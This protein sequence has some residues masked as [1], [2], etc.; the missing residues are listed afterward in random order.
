MVQQSSESRIASLL[1]ITGVA[2]SSLLLASAAMAWTGAVP[3]AVDNNPDPNIFETTLNV[4]RILSWD[5]TKEGETPAMVAEYGIAFNDQVPGPTI[6][7]K[8]GDRVIVHVNNN[9]PSNLVNGEEQFIENFITVHWHGMELNNASDGTPL[10]QN[11]ISPGGGNFSYDFIVTRPGVFWYHPHVAPTDLVFRGNYGAIIVTDEAEETALISAGILPS[12]KH[13]LVLADTTVCGD[14][15]A[16]TDPPGII[17]MCSGQAPNHVPPVQPASTC[18][19]GNCQVRQ[20]HRV[21]SNGRPVRNADVL[22]VPLG[23]GVR[24]QA[25]NVAINRY[26]RLHAQDTNGNMLDLFRVGG[27]G[28]LLDEARLEGGVVGGLDTEYTRGELLLAPADRADFVVFFPPT[29]QVGDVFTIESDL[30]ANPYNNTGQGVVWSGLAATL[31]PVVRMVIVANPTPPSAPYSIAEGTLLGASGL[32]NVSPQPTLVDEPLGELFDPGLLPGQLPFAGS[33]TILDTPGSNDPVI[34]MTNNAPGPS[35]DGVAGHFDGFPCEAPPCDDIAGG[36]AYQRI[37]HIE[38][39]RFAFSESVLELFIQNR[40]NAE[41]PFHL[42]GF[43]FQP[44]SMSNN[45]CTGGG[46]SPNE[47]CEVDADC[48]GG[49]ATCTGP[50]GAPGITWDWDYNEFVD[51]LNIKPLETLK[52]RVKLEARPMA[53]GMLGETGGE[54][55]RWV[56][57]CHIFHHAAL[58]MISELV[59]LPTSPLDA[60]FV[61]DQTGSFADDL[62]AFK[63]AASDVVTTLTNVAPGARAAIAEFRDYPI[64]PWG[65]AS[66]QPYALV[67]SFKDL[68]VA[69]EQVQFLNAIMNMGPASGGADGPEAQLTALQQS[70]LGAGQN[71]GSPS[72]ADYIAPST[73]GWSTMNPSK[74]FLLWTDASYHDPAVEPGYPGPTF[75]QAILDVKSLDPPMVVGLSSGIGAAGLPGLE[76]IATA[77]GAIAASPV[78]CDDDGRADILPGEPLVCSI[79]DAGEGLNV[80]VDKLLRA[81]LVTQAPVARCQDVRKVGECRADVSIDNDSTDPQGDPITLAQTPP[82]PYSTGSTPV[83]LRVTDITGRSDTCSAVVT[84][85]DEVAP[86]VACNAPEVITAA[87]MPLGIRATAIDNCATDPVPSITGVECAGECDVSVQG[88]ILTVHAASEGSTLFWQPVVNDNGGNTSS[89]QCYTTVPEPGTSW[90]LALGAGLLCLLAHRGHRARRT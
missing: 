1:R 10:T 65:G 50:G 55:G 70:A 71:T 56:F 49:G 82:G 37:P 68:S 87:D 54:E 59:V 61:V 74:I 13:V 4:A 30:A 43:S 45:R 28:G 64:S 17:S 5:L 16:G 35:I 66:D 67:E 80:A 60:M 40:T 85:L 12:D 36:D 79:G 26:F 7:V 83:E 90:T 51:N 6:N 62:A 21:L 11:P 39:S 77:T 27:Q 58:G 81:A 32:P 89:T 20:G 76:A 52:F 57:H 25:L 15:S 34:R 19:P 88:P 73:P 24:F 23:T 33:P 84:V 63:T 8:V 75:D 78:D 29:A 44:M 9:L 53:G 22:E 31:G 41:H 47:Y 14:V 48:G 69:A 46:P 72:A 18:I 86:S 2:L 3:S 38:T 42:H